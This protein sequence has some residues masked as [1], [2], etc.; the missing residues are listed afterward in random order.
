ML[1]HIR[2]NSRNVRNSDWLHRV[3]KPTARRQFPPEPTPIYRNTQT[4]KFR[5]SFKRF[6]VLVALIN[7][8]SFAGMKNA[9]RDRK[10]VSGSCYNRRRISN[11]GSQ[12][13]RV[14]RDR[15]FHRY[16]QG[17]NVKSF[18]PARQCPQNGKPAIER[19]GE[20]GHLNSVGGDVVLSCLRDGNRNGPSR[21][22]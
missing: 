13:A 21:K 22:F 17:N 3:P 5:W 12:A 19:R 18:V 8:E 15:F 11:L 1:S 6:G 4:R 10:G 9:T 14:K 16:S 7:G 2:S 20:T